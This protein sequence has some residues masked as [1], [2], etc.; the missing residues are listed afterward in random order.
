MAT[1]LLTA[2]NGG[3]WHKNFTVRKWQTILIL[4]TCACVLEYICMQ[5][6]TGLEEGMGTSGAEIRGG[7]GLLGVGLRDSVWTLNR[8]PS[9]QSTH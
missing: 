1:S 5:I 7:C 9:P 3:E 6:V 2:L 4:C 8:Q